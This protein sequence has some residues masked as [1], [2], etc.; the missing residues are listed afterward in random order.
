MVVENAN[1]VSVRNVYQTRPDDPVVMY[2][3][4]RDLAFLHWRFDPQEIQSR[5]PLGLTVDT[6]DGVAWLGIVSFKM[7]QIRP[8]WSP[9]VPYF[10]NFLELNVRTYVHDEHGRPGVYFVSL[11]A[12]R[13]LA[14]WGAKRFYHLPYHWCSMSETMDGKSHRFNTQRKSHPNQVASQFKYRPTGSPH[15]TEP[16]T[17]EYFLAE[18]YLLFTERADGTLLSGQVHHTP[19]PVQKLE[20][21]ECDSHLLQLDGFS[22]S[23]EFPEHALFS[24]G[25]DTEVFAFQ[26]VSRY[27]PDT[28]RELSMLRA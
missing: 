19:Y 15:L 11:N 17:L 3:N 9:V 16:G 26:D 22:V 1:S 23:S 18:R 20:V 13:W 28:M 6:F 5:L 7:R 2:Q 24:P 25:V 21:M 10:S 8:V 4:W 27:V 12:D 14:V